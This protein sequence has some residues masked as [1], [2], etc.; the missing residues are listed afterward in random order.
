[1]D[2]YFVCDTNVLLET[3]EVIHKHKIVI[4]SHVNREL[5]K[6]KISG[7]DGLAYKAR[8]ATRYIEENLDQVLFDV[9]DYQVTF[10]EE[11]DNNYADNKII[12]CCLRNEYGVITNDLLLRQKARL[13]KIEIAN[14]SEIGESFDYTGYKEVYLSP[15]ELDKM[16]QSL[17]LNVYKLLTNEY[18]IIKDIST[19]QE[20]KN[21]EKV[22]SFLRWNGTSHVEVKLP[23]RNKIS[24]QHYLQTCAIDL[25]YNKNI[26]I[27]IICGTFGS[28]KT[29][30]ATK[31]GVDFVKN[32]TDGYS[33]IMV[34]R[35]PIGSGEEIGFLKGSKDEKTADFFKP[36]VQHLKDGDF[37]AQ[38]MEQNGQLIKEIPWHMKGLS[39]ED[40]F[41]LVDEA[42]DLTKKIVKLL[43]TRLAKN[44]CIVFSGDFEQAE[45]KYAH[46]NGL[47]IAIENLKGDP[48][49]G[50]IILTEDV[51]SEASK[52]FA[53]L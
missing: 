3:P 45:D 26:P 29:Y 16:F 30:L 5:E 19:K 53:K 22:L 9:K 28:G 46:N 34:V 27:K 4:L 12:E 43:G 52:V 42:E 49:V 47:K 44:S 2:K 24:P 20:D 51:R 25:L 37:E 8:R 17:D 48:L 23:S 21:K 36:V 38:L 15:S 41:I 11:F 39:I 50:I 10:G 14:L 6:H 7:K 35:N 18:L 40:T 1:M 31:A 32:R 33:K 13:Y